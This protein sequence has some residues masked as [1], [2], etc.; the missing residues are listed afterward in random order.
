VAVHEGKPRRVIIA[1]LPR[2]EVTHELKLPD[3]VRSLLK[4]LSDVTV[5]PRTGD[6]LLLSDQSRRIVGVRIVARRLV[7]CG[8][9]DL[10]LSRKEKPEGLDFAS[11]SR[12]LVVTDDAAKLLE[13]AVS[14]RAARSY[15]PGREYT[16]PS[17]SL[18]PR[19][20]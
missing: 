15:I 18:G 10:P 7:V 14:R 2:L 11:D 19:T 12:L 17:T 1:A 8:S 4:D 9:Y 6:L 20:E 16:R 5:D 3:E 13:I